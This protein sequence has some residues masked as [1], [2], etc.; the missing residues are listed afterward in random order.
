MTRSLVIVGGEEGKDKGIEQLLFF[1]NL[2]KEEKDQ[3]PY[4]GHWF[5]FPFNQTGEVTQEIILAMMKAQNYFLEFQ[6]SIA[7]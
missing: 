4:T 2:S 6:E 7:V 1:N 3:W 5:F